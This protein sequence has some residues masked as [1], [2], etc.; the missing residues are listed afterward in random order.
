MKLLRII[1]K[2]LKI[3]FRSKSS[4]FI[5]ILGP[6]IL[7]AL[8]SLAV[9]NANDYTIKIAVFELGN[10]EVNNN[11][12]NLLNSEGYAITNYQDLDTCIEN[13][14]INNNDVCLVLPKTFLS[15]QSNKITVY[16]DQSRMNFIDS[17]MITISRII[18]LNSEEISHSLTT[19]L[20]ST[21][22]NA[23]DTNL[24]NYNLNEINKNNLEV[25]NQKNNKIN[26]NSDYDSKIINKVGTNEDYLEDL[27]SFQTDVN[28]DIS[29]LLE[30]LEEL[31]DE[32]DTKNISLT[33]YNNVKTE[34]EKLEDFD[35]DVDELE[36]V[37][38]TLNS[39][40]NGLKKDLTSLSSGLKEI[41]SS[42][43]EI[44]NKNSLI[45][46]NIDKIETNL[47]QIISEIEQLRT[48]SVDN[49]VNPTTIEKKYV[50]A[51]EN[52]SLYFLPDFLTV[53][54]IFVGIMLSSTLVVMEK[55]SKAHFR[56]F[57]TPTGET[58]QVLGRYCT[59]FL[60]AFF[61]VIFILLFGKYV[62]K[63]SLNIDYWVVVL[64][65]ITSLTFFIFLGHIIGYISRTQEGNF[66]ISTLVS[67]VMIFFS[68]LILPVET[69]S[70]LFQ[71]ILSFNPF[72][73]SSKILKKGLI[74]SKDLFSC[75]IEFFTLLGYIFLTIIFMLVAYKISLS[76]LI[77]KIHHKKY[78]KLPHVTPEHY[79][80][81]DDGNL[82][83]NKT[84][85]YNQIKKMNIKEINLYQEEFA[86]WLKIAF[87]DKKTAKK[88]K[89]AKDKK[90][91][92]EILKK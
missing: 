39:N 42:S 28:S 68:N 1:V 57:I 5:I 10:N 9:S 18:N 21:V 76:D 86:D 54:I 53:V 7:V 92:L 11:V 82:I 30:D 85:L 91:I 31:L 4:A 2:N 49:I 63:L 55:K 70:L 36:D 48:I 75:Q 78:F 81:L 17:V 6:L 15:N 60:I 33:N 8:I 87:K 25:I 90:E 20:V 51:S 34:F 69:Y 65:I 46:E 45:L 67:S 14:E 44:K 50:V 22:Q 71:E 88:I 58:I 77:P 35:E 12:K 26:S 80:R 3:L 13:V 32:I 47:D 27:E 52:K 64:G 24:E 16:V 56:N 66:M 41:K 73:I 72:I 37:F 38:D 84:E 59:T 89:K 83:K 61:Q 79:F 40:F 74:Y 29:S 43:T 62:L 23:Y 19:E